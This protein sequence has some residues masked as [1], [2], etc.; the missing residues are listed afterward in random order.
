MRLHAPLD[1]LPADAYERRVRRVAAAWAAG[2]LVP[3]ASRE[4]T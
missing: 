2:D 1:H 4:P 3:D